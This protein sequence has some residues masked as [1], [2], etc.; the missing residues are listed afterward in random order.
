[1]APREE[2]DFYL[3][4]IDDKPASICLNLAASVDLSRPVRLQVLLKLVLPRQ[5]DG[6]SSSDEAKALAALEDA[7]TTRL[8]G[9]LD[10]EYVGRWTC[11]GKREYVF[12]AQSEHGFLHAT[13]AVQR[14]FSQYQLKCRAEKDPDWTMFEETL[15][16]DALEMQWIYDRRVVDQ[17]EQ[18]GD[19]AAT[20]RPV[21]HFV[22]FPDAAKREAF[23]QAARAQ[24]FTAE[25]IQGDEALG[26]ELVREDPIQLPHIHG[27]VLGLIALAEQHGGDYDGWGAPVAGKPASLAPQPGRGS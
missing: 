23:M 21:D 9:A 7:L 20:P 22:Y 5:Q 13:E 2:W 1:M 10:A 8:C 3:T 25:P 4:R 12:Y 27:V 18:H 17:L 6:L 15:R 26:V 16:P 24:G 19:D 11:A 14:E